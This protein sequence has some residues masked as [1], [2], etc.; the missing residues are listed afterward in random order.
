MSSRDPGPQKKQ[1]TS[2]HEFCVCAS[3]REQARL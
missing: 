2:S 1:V 3:S